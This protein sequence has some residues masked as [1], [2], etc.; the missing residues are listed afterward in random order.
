[1]VAVQASLIHSGDN[2]FFE[3]AIRNLVIYN[4]VLSNGEIATLNSAL[5]GG[6]TPPPPAP[7][8]NVRIIR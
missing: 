7:P 2:Q 1:M 6:T 4:R 5:S 3:G 8:Q